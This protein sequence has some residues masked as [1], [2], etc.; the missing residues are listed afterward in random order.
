MI[1]NNE[2]QE[3]S[4]I[5]GIDD[6]NASCIFVDFNVIFFYEYIGNKCQQSNE[7]NEYWI[8]HLRI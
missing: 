5:T 4:S 2:S 8:S 1:I 3:Q 6:F 7:W